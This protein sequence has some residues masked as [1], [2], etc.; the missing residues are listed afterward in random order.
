MVE[1][2]NSTD[3]DGCGIDVGSGEDG[4]VVDAAAMMMDCTPIFCGY[5]ELSSKL[6]ILPLAL[7]LWEPCVL[8]CLDCCV[9]VAFACSSSIEVRRRMP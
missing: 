7:E 5:S 3:S 6:L 1:A 2:P 8:G 4:V 9:V